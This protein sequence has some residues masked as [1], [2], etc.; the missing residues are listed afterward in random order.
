MEY[1]AD[2]AIAFS[3]RTQT[4]LEASGWNI[5]SLPAGLT[6]PVLRALGAPFRGDRYFNEFAADVVEAPTVAQSIA[7]QPGILEGSLNLSY[8]QAEELVAAFNRTVPDGGRAIIGQA[9]ACV[10]VLWQ[11]SQKTGQFPLAG[12]Y[13]WASD[14]YGDSH[15]VVGLFGR[16][17]PII[18]APHPKS[19]RGIGVIPLIVPTATTTPSPRSS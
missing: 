1:G 2:G 9:A 4:T 10:H 19:G 18:V 15:L 3:P 11:H 17:R 6:L 5:I 16:S 12:A 7:Y 13:T 8:S 14:G